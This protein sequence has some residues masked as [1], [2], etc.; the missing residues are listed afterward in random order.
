MSDTHQAAL[1]TDREI[2]REREGDYY[3]DSIHVTAQGGIG[4]NCGGL[5]IVKSLRDWHRLESELSSQKVLFDEHTKAVGKFLSDMYAVMVDPLDS[6]DLKVVEMCELLL[7]AACENRQALQDQLDRAGNLP[8]N[9]KDDSSLETW[10]PLTAEELRRKDAELSLLRG[11]NERLKAPVSDGE[12]RYEISL[13]KLLL[14]SMD[15]TPLVERN[16]NDHD[17]DREAIARIIARL[18]L[19]SGAELVPEKGLK[20]SLMEARERLRHLPAPD[21][22]RWLE[23][24]NEGAGQPLPVPPKEATK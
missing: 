4:I 3:A 1:N 2:W 16:S 23:E 7:N 13:M 20:E 24:R 11:E 10:F 18:K 12:L 5:V 6:S 17:V 8:A 9:W 19:L 21:I 22:Q 15:E 14:S